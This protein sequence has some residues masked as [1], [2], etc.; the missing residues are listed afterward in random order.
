MYFLIEAETQLPSDM[1]DA[2]RADLDEREQRVGI[3]LVRTGRIAH[4]WRVPGRQANIAI[5]SCEDA[6]DLH[7]SLT[8]LPAW[9]WMDV[10]VQPLATHPLSAVLEVVET[11]S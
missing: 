1:T 5:W 2:A 8:A 6:D 7:T 11:A 9:P 3:E 10:T 4:I